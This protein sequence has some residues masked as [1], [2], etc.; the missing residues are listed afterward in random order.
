MSPGVTPSAG[1]TLPAV[2]ANLGL[3]EGHILAYN[4]QKTSFCR[5]TLEIN[6]VY[7]NSEAYGSLTCMDADLDW[8][9]FVSAKLIVFAY[10]PKLFHTN[11]LWN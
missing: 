3:L 2:I 4:E 5:A 7:G 1:I 9:L 8:D 10:F 6:A 11:P